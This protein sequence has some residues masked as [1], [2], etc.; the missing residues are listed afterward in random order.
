MERSQ[1]NNLILLVVSFLIFVVITVL[2]ALLTGRQPTRDLEERAST[3]FTDPSGTSATFLVLQRLL[4][5]VEVWRRP[6]LYL[7]PPDEGGP[8][9]LVVSAPSRPLLTDE[10]EALLQWVICGRSA[11]LG[12]RARLARRTS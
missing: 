3:F 11:S 2:A 7:T 5:E 6:L 12:P 9:T 4:P 1:R 10:R 8:S